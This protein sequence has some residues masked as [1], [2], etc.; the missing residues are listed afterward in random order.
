VT[1]VMAGVVVGVV[2]ALAFGLATEPAVRE[3]VR[4]LAAPLVSLGCCGGDGDADGGISVQKAADFGRQVL[5]V[6]KERYR[7]AV[8]ESR[9]AAAEERQRL[10]A[11]FERA[12][13]TGRADTDRAGT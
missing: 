6:A 9:A 3:R 1:R 4:K 2:A 8:E 10:W 13:D 7:S 11:R 12:R 5:G